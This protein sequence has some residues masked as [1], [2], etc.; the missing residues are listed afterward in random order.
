MIEWTI[1]TII[2][3]TVMT[4]GAIA[5]VLA[6]IYRKKQSKSIKICPDLEII[7]NDLKNLVK[8]VEDF[9]AE[10]K[11]VLEKEVEHSQEIHKMLFDKVS[12][13]S[14]KIDYVRGQV[15]QHLKNTTQ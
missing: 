15:D 3:A 6:R 11:E 7:K 10:I 13:V 4:V 1:D 12:E 2:Y 9:E 14:S 8:N 5:G